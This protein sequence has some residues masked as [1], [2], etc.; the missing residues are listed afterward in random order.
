VESQRSLDQANIMA[1]VLLEKGG[2]KEHK[3]QKDFSL[4]IFKCTK[5]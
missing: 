5:E 4:P 3:R 1:E 2:I